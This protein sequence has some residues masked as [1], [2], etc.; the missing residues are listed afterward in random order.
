VR[1]S[2]EIKLGD[3]GFITDISDPTNRWW[4]IEINFEPFFDT[5]F[6]L[7]NTKQ[8]VHSFKKID[9]GEAI[10]SDDEDIVFIFISALSEF[11]HNQISKIKKDIDN[12]DKGTRGGGF[13]PIIPSP[14]STGTNDPGP[15]PGDTV[16]VPSTE[17]DTD[18]DNQE[19]AAER[20]ELKKWLLARYPEYSND[21]VKLSLAIEWFFS[22]DYKQ[23]FVFLQLGPTDIYGFD[24]IGPR[25]II[26]INTEHEFYREF[27]KPIFDE[28]NIDRIHQILLLFGSM[29]ESEK[30]LV[31]YKNYIQIYRGQF[32]LNL[33]QFILDWRESR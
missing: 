1:A 31:S 8:N 29:V 10:D 9:S 25:T 32:G 20:E 28:N 19:T 6:G 3:F 15:F 16:V 11:I 24:V 26:E 27:I 17:S 30:R 18:D 14:I 12:I 2:R 22:T 7:D 23:I 13:S 5:F 21:E 33:G 4:K